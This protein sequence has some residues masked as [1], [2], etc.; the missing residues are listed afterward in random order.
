MDSKPYKRTVTPFRWRPQG[1]T[2]NNSQDEQ[3]LHIGD[4]FSVQP[5]DGSTVSTIYLI[6]KTPKNFGRQNTDLSEC[7]PYWQYNPFNMI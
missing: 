7:S 2:G 4:H 6:E 3:G 5:L 1:Q